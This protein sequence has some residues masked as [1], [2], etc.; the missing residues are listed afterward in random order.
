MPAGA[1]GDASWVATARTRLAEGAQALGI[2]A[3]ESTLDRLIAYVANLERWGRV[4]NLTAVRDPLAMVSAHV[5]DCLAALETV[6]HNLSAPPRAIIDVG[7]GAG[8]PG[9]VLA[10]ARPEWPVHLVEPVG[11]KAAFLRQCVGEFALHRAT[12]HACRIEDVSPELT[13]VADVV[14]CRAFATLDTFVTGARHLA[15]SKTVFVAMKG[16]R[17]REEAAAFEPQRSGP[18]SAVIRVDETI[19]LHVPFLESTRALVVLRMHDARPARA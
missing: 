10:I 15:D 11:K 3:N 16:A 5:L 7:S 9:I 19:T 14:I 8:L 6:R 12:V 18:S 13:G 4:F 17:A 1:S 2:D